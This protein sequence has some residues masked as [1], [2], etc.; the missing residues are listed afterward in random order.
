MPLKAVAAQIEQVHMEKLAEYKG[1]LLL[2]G[3]CYDKEKK[4]Y[5]CRIERV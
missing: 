3:I 2:V 4:I 1:N 5:E